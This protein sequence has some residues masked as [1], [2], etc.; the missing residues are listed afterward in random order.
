MDF[1]A[2]RRLVRMAWKSLDGIEGDSCTGRTSEKSFECRAKR[3]C[4][5][6][7]TTRNP[8]THSDSTETVRGRAHGPVGALLLRLGACLAPRGAA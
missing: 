2:R 1:K 7:R 3:A 4:C 8:A 5:V 6:R